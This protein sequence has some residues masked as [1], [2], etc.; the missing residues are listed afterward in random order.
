MT[1]QFLP[2]SILLNLLFGLI[3]H[4]I[5]GWPLIFA[6]LGLNLGILAFLLWLA[7]GKTSTKEEK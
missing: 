5:G 7:Y 1:D 6:W 4:A 3:L 2:T